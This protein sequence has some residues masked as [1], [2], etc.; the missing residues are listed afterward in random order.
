MIWH[1]LK[2]IFFTPDFVSSKEK[3]PSLSPFHMNKSY[4][5][6]I[7]SILCCNLAMDRVFFGEKWEQFSHQFSIADILHSKTHNSQK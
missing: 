6:F 7:W 3:T 1:V 4:Y 2:M 5:C